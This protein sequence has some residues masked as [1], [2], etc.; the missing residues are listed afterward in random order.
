[1]T[2]RTAAQPLPC[3]TWPSPITAANVADHYRTVSFPLTKDGE[4]WWQE[5]LPGEQGRSTV[6]HL[7]ADGKP[8]QLLSAPWNARTRVHEYGGRAYL[9]VRAGKPGSRPSRQRGWAIVFANFADQRLYLMDQPGADD[10][11]TTPR[12]LSPAPGEEGTPAL[13]YAD[14]CLS[15]DGAEVWCVQ[16]CHEAGKVT[17]AIVAVPLDGSA[18]EQAGAIR[19]LVSGADFYAFPTPSPDGRRLAWISWNHPRMPWDGTELRVASVD[20]G[21]PGKGW[22]IKG[23]IGESVLAPAWRDDT[24]LYLISDWPGWWNLYTLNLTGGL[25]E[26]IYPAEEEFAGPLW[27]LG[28]S[29]YAVLADGRLAVLHGCGGMRL[30]LLDPFTGEFTEVDI[31]YRIFSS[32]LSADGMTIVGVAGGPSTAMSVVRIDTATGRVK[33]LYSP[34]RRLPASGYLPKVRKLELEGRFGQTVHAWVYP[35]ANPDATVPEGELPP[36][37]VWA[38]G[39]PASHADRRLD[40]EKAYFTSRGIGVIDVNYG[41]STG[42]GRVYRERLRRQWGVVDVED[43]IAAAQALVEDDEADGG[44]LVIRGGSAGGWTA[45]AAVTAAAGDSP[46]KAATSYYGITDLR[47]FAA[48]TH[49][50][51]SRYTDGLVGPLPGFAA[52]FAERSPAH[53][54]SSRTCP[55]LQLQGQDDVIVPPA[56]A[57]A[58]AAQLT[59]QGI[60]HALLEFKEESHGFGRTE[61]I[62]AALEAELSL[63]AQALNFPHPDSPLLRLHTT[64][65]GLPT[66]EAEPAPSTE[67]PPAPEP[68]PASPPTKRAA[69]TAP[70]PRDAVAHE[71]PSR[72]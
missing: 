14:F 12:P 18:A 50:F 25:A 11:G 41:G 7:G 63:Y 28:E 71:Q 66:S 58:L 51:E 67:A 48:T 47:N 31:P 53:R 59:H 35:P 10:A 8:R 54:V 21:V 56:Q 70:A 44:R 61:T 32:G 22:L 57:H 17:R 29:P 40:L 19:E 60:P 52:A 45:L 62:I 2:E 20:N 42:Y 37:V 3:G 65:P 27:R 55:I 24:S 15:P 1:M 6:V 36:Y 30:A 68:P 16:E 46:F 13:R 34:A 72:A 39:G 69:A 4:V 5:T 23:G 9:P 64:T 49:D 33:K 43:V 38:H 26:P